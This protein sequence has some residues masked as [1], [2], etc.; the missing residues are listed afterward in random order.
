VDPLTVGSWLPESL[1]HNTPCLDRNSFSVQTQTA[2]VL[3]NP[4]A[5]FDRRVYC[6]NS[7]VIIA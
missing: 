7:N 4:V 5:E 2:P 1:P 6:G 3:G